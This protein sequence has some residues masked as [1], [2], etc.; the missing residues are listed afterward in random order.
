MK[1]IIAHLDMDAFFAAIEER[2]SPQFKG[3][4]LVIGA[5]PKNGMGRGVV[6]T[7][8]YKA[9]EYGIRSAMPIS[10]AWKLSEEARKRR[11]MPTIFLPVDMQK[12]LRVSR[13]IQNR[14]KKL[15]PLVEMASIDEAY[16]DLSYTK[17]YTKAIALCQ[18]IKREIKKELG[19]TASIGLGPNKL[20]AK[21]ASDRE[22]PDGLTVV[23]E[24]Q[25]EAFLDPL[26]VRT[27]PGIGP[28]TE[29]IFQQKGIYTIHDLK[30]YSQGDLGGL[31]G[32][33]GIELYDRIRGE[34]NSPVQEFYETKS[35]GE[36]ETFNED[37]LDSRIIFERLKLLCDGVIHS[38]KKESFKAFRTVVLT[39]RFENFVTQSTSHTLQAPESNADV[40]YREAM[41]LMMPY[42]DQRKNPQHL[43]IRLVGIRVE[44]FIVDDTK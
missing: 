30:K 22:K 37:T 1:R 18:R 13:E 25:K 34:D 4:P 31:L 7:A 19:L 39:V 29:K 35:V 15:V 28:K 21:I 16:L 20:I 44:K 33:W 9:R 5:D 42:L 32:K 40:L 12:Y 41:K 24:E 36:Q 27:M 17:S 6:S 14:I 43:K 3:A 2:D 10:R 8:N 38:F 26:P 23:P 11:E